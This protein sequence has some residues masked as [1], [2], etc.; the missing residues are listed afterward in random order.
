MPIGLGASGLPVGIQVAGK[1]YSER[2]L[3]AIAKAL[4]NYTEKFRYP[5]EYALRMVYEGG[6]AICAPQAVQVV[7]ASGNAS[8]QEGQRASP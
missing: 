2:R 3:L 5:F 1:R 7:A 6:F 4:D 8:M